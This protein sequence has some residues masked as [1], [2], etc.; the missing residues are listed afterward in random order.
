M[1]VGNSSREAG[2]WQWRYESQ[3]KK[4]EG[5]RV[6][7]Q[8]GNVKNQGIYAGLFLDSACRKV[9]QVEE[10]EKLC[11]YLKMGKESRFLGF[12]DGTK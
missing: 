6:S 9:C 7:I 5:C 12:K 2:R 3:I 10:Y 4:Y 11:R 8:P 1:G